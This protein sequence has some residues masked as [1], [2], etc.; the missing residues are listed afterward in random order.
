[1]NAAPLT[2]EKN[3]TLV[4]K[5]QKVPQWKHLWDEARVL[6]QNQ[7]TRAAII[8]YLEVLEIKPNIEEVKWE[9]SRNYLTLKQFD[10]A[11]V[12]LQSLLEA[13]PEKIEY[14]VSAGEAAMQM[15][16]ASLAG[17]YFG[18]A[19]ALDPG[20]FF[21][22]LA[23]LGMVEA[24]SAQ[25]KKT[26]T[27]PLM[28]QL[29][30]REV[31]D[32][33]LL[34]DLAQFYSDQHDYAAAS[35]Y[36]RELIEKYRVEDRIITEAAYAYEK[37]A[38]FD[39][40]AEQWEAYLHGHPDYIQFRIKLSDY[41]LK[42]EKPQ[43]ALPHLHYLLEHD[44]DRE[45][46]L[47]QVAQTYLYMIGRSDKAL[48]YFEQYRQEFP[49]GIDVSNEIAG[50]QM[51]LANDLLA[52]VENDGVWM[53]WRDLAEVTP[54]RIAIYRAM[55]KTLMD[56]GRN[57][58][59]ELIEI[60]KIINAHD[61]ED[62]DT[63]SQLVRLYRKT[64]RLAECEEFLDQAA[65]TNGNT[66]EFYLLRIQCESSAGDDLGR[67]KSYEAYLKLKP[68]DDNIRIKA[69][70]L[71]GSLGFVE[72]L[73]KI[74]QK[75]SESG[76]LQA[77]DID[78]AY[79]HELLRNGL[80]RAA[81]AFLE[82]FDRVKVDNEKQKVL[83][84]ELAEIDLQQN[85]PYK[86][87][88]TLRTYAS[89]TTENMDGYLLLSGFFM[90][91][92]D[93]LAATFWHDAI[94]LQ[95][96]Q[97]NS[98]QKSE[99]FYQKL[100]IDRE[101]AKV[102]AYQQAV[103]YLNFQLKRNRIVSEDVNV[104]LFAAEHYLQTN[105]FDNC[106]RLINRFRPKFKGIDRVT[107]TL[108]IAQKDRA[109]RTHSWLKKPL[110]VSFSVQIAIAEQLMRMGRFE[111]A[112]IVLKNIS[113][114]LPESTRAKVLLAEVHMSLLAYKNAEQIF[115]GLAES[116]DKET[117]FIEQL[118][119]LEKLQGLSESIFQEFNVVVDD[120]GRKNTIHSLHECMDY[121]EIKLMWARSLWTDDKWE[122][123]LDVYGLIDTEMK[124]K[125]DLLKQDLEQI[126]PDQLFPLPFDIAEHGLIFDK[127][128]VID[129]I[130]SNEFIVE[131]LN[132]D[133]ART[134]SRYYDSY[135]W[136]KIISKEMTAKSSLKAKEFYQAEIDYKK[137]LQEEEDVTEPIYSDLATVY[138][139]LGREQ[140]ETEIL[141][142]IKE[143]K[144]KY[145]ELT[146][147]SEKN[148][149][150]R[151]P[152]LSLE[153]NYL[154]EKG[155]DGY[156]DIIQ[157]N[158]GLGLQAKPTLYQDVGFVFGHNEYG[159]SNSSTLAKSNTILGNYK[160]QFNDIIE[161]S[162]KLGIEDFD[163][164]GDTFILY[165]FLLRG[166]LEQR[167]ELYAG[168][169]QEPIDD[170][171]DS[172]LG[173]IYRRDMQLGFSLDYFFGMFFGF[174]IDLYDYNDNNDGEQYYLWSSYRW[175]G[176]RSSLDITYSYLNLQ[177]QLTNEMA[178]EA[179]DDFALPYWSPGEYWKHRLS[180]MYKVE[181]WP[182]GRLHSGTGSFSAKYGIGYEKGDSLIHEI[183]MNILLEITTSILVKGTFSTLLSEDYDQIQGYAS[184]VY[185]W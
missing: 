48:Y 143:T 73:G 27:I 107:A 12:I 28:E 163:E 180:G 3:I 167:V 70:Q 24:L 132:G 11:L 36:Y 176:D 151:Q 159:N 134:G 175:F 57:K 183:D 101:M 177:N 46:Y 170:T 52:I 86:A 98:A 85:R 59:N 38:Y 157:R 23:L 169:K 178:I 114:E 18:Q 122:E 80:P 64:G 1:M 75:N 160:I 4:T 87:E 15:Q 78:Y 53:L 88:Q 155:R 45:R 61:P 56:M 161:G 168:I 172:L 10:K 184:V 164:D 16:K 68:G 153:G 130:M 111:D 147:I 138:G 47:L 108:V 54:G 9:L 117:Y 92:K 55:A 141:E 119:R 165:D 8:R 84:R 158:I 166:S 51:I 44:I 69:M 113:A 65:D 118:F 40:A 139:R 43:D 13:S 63:I 74:Y 62:I 2:P 82:M 58:E 33:E 156:I 106:I 6:A 152:H 17:R 149:R 99:L 124:R 94:T 110:E 66:A 104:L 32:Q 121:P 21:S 76:N 19:L 125:M 136:G 42:E 182:T 154:K 77:S 146:R 79:A 102:D 89:Y 60:L 5:E 50:L 31:I 115:E 181:L 7:E 116:Y 35:F 71:A 41:Y 123:S 120:S 100:L 127:P 83:V 144:I 126:P 93:I 179:V 81:E 95:E 137:L 39:E 29:I 173:G 109:E 128:E 142:K 49:D 185:L 150:S 25:G 112:G 91:K 97:L 135:R 67:L 148:I 90:D 96:R 14:L 171:I 133:I 30:Q 131:N 105:R 37:S 20:G 34:H 22:E 140:E 145:P 162:G 174:D 26:L 72:K 129:L 103:Q